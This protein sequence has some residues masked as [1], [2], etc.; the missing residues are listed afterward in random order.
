MSPVRVYLSAEG[1]EEYGVPLDVWLESTE[2]L[3]LNWNEYVVLE[4]YKDIWCSTV[5]I[6]SNTLN[7]FFFLY[8]TEINCK[9]GGKLSKHSL[10]CYNI[11]D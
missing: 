2:T 9:E 6:M 1:A 4:T 10:H 7:C 5:H 8:C 3:K 11:Q